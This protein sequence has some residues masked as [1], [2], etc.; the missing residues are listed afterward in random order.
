MKNR[1]IEEVLT[2]FVWCKRELLMEELEQVPVYRGG[3]AQSLQFSI[4]WNRDILLCFKISPTLLS[5]GS[6]KFGFP[7]LLLYKTSD[8][9]ATYFTYSS[10]IIG[11][12][13]F[14]H[15]QTYI[16]DCKSSTENFIICYT[17][18]E[19]QAI[20]HSISLIIC[21]PSIATGI[22]QDS[23]KLVNFF[24]FLQRV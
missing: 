6:F 12:V 23:S 3:K 10:W 19:L 22:P 1:Y 18:E 21:N 20:L 11:K 16:S 7:C 9:F 14:S 24:L 13:S 2:A 15:P 5:L 4:M 8:V 17:F